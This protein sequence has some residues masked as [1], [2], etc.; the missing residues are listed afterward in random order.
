[1]RRSANRSTVTWS[2][3]QTHTPETRVME[4]VHGSKACRLRLIVDKG[5]ITL[6]D[7]EYTFDVICC[8]AGEMILESADCGRRGEVPHPKCVARLLGLPWRTSGIRRCRFSFGALFKMACMV[9]SATLSPYSRPRD[10]A[11]DC[12]CFR[13][14]N[15]LKHGRGYDL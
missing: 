13:I 6:R 11:L 7:Q 9:K 2:A 5:A 15:V 3:H 4:P 12:G 1:M 14:Q 10:A 8:F